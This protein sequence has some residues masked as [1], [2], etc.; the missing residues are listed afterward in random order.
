MSPSFSLRQI[1]PLLTTGH[2]TTV[3]KLYGSIRAAIYLGT[4]HGSL[5]NHINNN[6]LK[7]FNN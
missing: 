6:K 3:V 4:S 7:V 1:N 5:L 2:I